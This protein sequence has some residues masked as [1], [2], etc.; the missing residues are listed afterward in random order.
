M[1]VPTPYMIFGYEMRPEAVVN[2]M[3]NS[4]A[5]MAMYTE[6][7]RRAELPRNE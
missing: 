5:K 6:G 2:E 3:P 1:S 4:S 7:P